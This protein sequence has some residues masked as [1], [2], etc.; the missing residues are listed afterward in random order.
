MIKKYHFILYSFFAMSNQLKY[1]DTIVSRYMM[2]AKYRADSI[3]LEDVEDVLSQADRHINMFMHDNRYEDIEYF[4]E[5]L[6]EVKPK[7]NKKIK[8]IKDYWGH[9][10]LYNSDWYASYID[11]DGVKY[12]ADLCKSQWDTIDQCINEYIATIDED[13]SLVHDDL[14]QAIYMTIVDL[15]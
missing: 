14:Y 1:D 5:Y 3:G 12:W 6:D 11:Y 15:Y 13:V 10:Q 9:I 7:Y 2:I 8:I 4:Q